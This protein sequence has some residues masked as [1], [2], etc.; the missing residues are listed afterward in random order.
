MSFR[1]WST[2]VTL[3]LLGV[4]VYFGWPEIE[5]AFRLFGQVNLWILLLLMP[6]QFFCYYAVGEVI[7]SYLKSKGDIKHMSRLLTT[8]FA[9]ELNFVNHIIPSGGVAGFSYFGWLLSKYGV[10]VGRSA[11]AQLVRY[12]L[13]FLA[14]TSIL[15]IAIIILIIEHKINSAILIISGILTVATIGIALL[16]V[17]VIKNKH[18]L[19]KFSIGLT[20]TINIILRVVTFGKKLDVVKQA[21][22]TNFFEDL[23]KD[24]VEIRQDKKLLLRPFIWSIVANLG[25]MALLSI[26]FMALGVWVSPAILFVAYGTAAISGF[27]SVTPGGVGAYEAIM[28]AFLASAGIPAGLAIA[29]TLVLRVSVLLGTIIFGYIFYQLTIF[30]YGKTP[31]HR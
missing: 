6:V 25:D 26:A 15:I 27:F 18:R 30:K 8:R 12:V 9:L 4:V 16:S 31:I 14:F 20:K 13:M 19:V 17:Y 10:G 29:G 22:I 28:V 3:I 1:S 5:H 11:M 2:I 21:K 23:H 7:F 24:Y